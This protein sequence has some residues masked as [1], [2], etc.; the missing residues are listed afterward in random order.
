[1]AVYRKGSS[2][3]SKSSPKEQGT[4]EHGTQ[5]KSAAFGH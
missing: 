1:M 3:D 2:T 5:I 4:R